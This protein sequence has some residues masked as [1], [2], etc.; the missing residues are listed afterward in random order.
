MLSKKIHSK[1]IIDL[2]N[3]DIPL[4]DIILQFNKVGLTTIKEKLGS[5]LHPFE[6]YILDYFYDGITTY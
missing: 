6:N 5:D 4:H 1:G 2:E 3:N